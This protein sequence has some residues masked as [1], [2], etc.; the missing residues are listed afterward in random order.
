MITTTLWRNYS[1]RLLIGIG[2]IAIFAISCTKQNTVSVP[3]SETPDTSAV[4]KYKGIFSPTSGIAIQGSAKIY[5][6]NGQYK[7]ALDSFQ[8]SNG[9]DLKVYLS[10][11]YPPNNFINLGALQ[12]T[13]GQQLYVIPGKPDFTVY[14]YALIHC[15]Q[16]NH[17][18]GIAE[19]KP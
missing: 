1:K 13:T 9:P 3:L 5:L 18:F 16:Y 10:K 11:E 6:A 8:V 19:L 2:I 17:L 7:L 15:Q 4:L 12:S 14:K